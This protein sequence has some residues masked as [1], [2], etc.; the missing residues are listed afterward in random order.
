MRSLPL[1]L[2][3]FAPT[4]ASAQI[5]LDITLTQGRTEEVFGPNDCGGNIPITWTLTP[6]INCTELRIWMTTESCLPDPDRAAGDLLILTEPANLQRFSD[7][8]DRAVDE[9]PLFVGADGGVSC[10][11]LGHDITWKLCGNTKFASVTGGTCDTLVSETS[12]P[13][14]RFDSKAPPAPAI[15]AVDERDSAIAVTVSVDANDTDTVIVV[16]TDPS[17][18]QAAREERATPISS[19][20]LGGLTNGTTYSI[21]AQARDAAGNLSELS[22]A[23]PATPVLTSGFFRR[24]VD[25]GGS[26]DG[27]CSSGG[28]AALG[29][30]SAIAGLWLA[31]R[32]RRK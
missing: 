24:Y 32:R 3:A 21:T 4:V 11:D 19:I 28:G 18:T 5:A 20:R 26:E 7:T 9:L 6:I 13:T 27:G 29:A 14:I 15:T 22:E 30:L 8:F 23:V 12:P 2:L 17:G 1:V 25:A 16:A 31:W 10:G